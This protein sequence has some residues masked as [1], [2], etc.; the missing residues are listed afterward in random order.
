MALTSTEILLLVMD[1][2]LFIIVVYLLLKLRSKKKIG[3]EKEKMQADT[4]TLFQKTGQ[5]VPETTASGLIEP[6]K[7]TVEKPSDPGFEQRVEAQ[8]KGT[9]ELEEKEVEV[10]PATSDSGDKAALEL[11][12]KP[13]EQPLTAIKDAKPG[14]IIQETDPLKLED[15]LPGEPS[16]I[17]AEPGAAEPEKARKTRK[18]S[19][20]KKAAKKK[21][22]ATDEGQTAGDGAAKDIISEEKTEEGAPENKPLF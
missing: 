2:V 3:P 20:K 10:T 19:R 8:E 12:D 22:P 13:P 15:N 4:A 6:E 17:G 18:R 1:I 9:L 7:T 5:G 16:S 21:K 14:K 11:E